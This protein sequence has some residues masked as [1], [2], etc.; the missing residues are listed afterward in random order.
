MKLKVSQV[1]DAT[2]ALARIMNEKRQMPQRGK[3]W[4]ARVH[5]KLLPEFNTAIAQRDA[6]ITEYGCRQKLL[7]A[8]GNETEGQGY[9]VPPDKMEEFTAAWQKIADEE[10]EVDVQ[11]VSLSMFDLGDQTNGAVEAGEL[12]ALGDMVVE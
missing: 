1:I 9:M 12:A 2:Y 4:L 6:M 3:Y 8:E 5:A 7:D 10:I 11:P